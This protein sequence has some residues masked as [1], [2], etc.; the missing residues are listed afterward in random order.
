MPMSSENTS[1]EPPV[2]ERGLADSVRDLLGGLRAL[3]HDR[4]QLLALETQQAIQ[5]LA[6]IAAYGIAV[7]L[8]VGGTWLALAGAMVMWLVEHQVSSSTAMLLAAAFNGLGIGGFALAIQR[9]S[10]HIGLPATLQSLKP[11]QA[12]PNTAAPLADERTTP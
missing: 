1:T 5:G 9:K 4:L 6:A 3:L 8:L 10:R 12:D 11:L 2:G 7:G